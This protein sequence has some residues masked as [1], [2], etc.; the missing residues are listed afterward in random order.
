MTFLFRLVLRLECRLLC[1]VF[2]L[3]LKSVVIFWSFTSD[4]T[5]ISPSV[6]NFWSGLH[7]SRRQLS[8]VFDI[9]P[10]GNMICNLLAYRALAVNIIQKI[11][12][13]LWYDYLYTFRS[14]ILVA[15]QFVSLRKDLKFYVYVIVLTFQLSNCISWSRVSLEKIIQCS[16]R[17]YNRFMEPRSSLPFSQEPTTSPYRD[18][19]QSSPRPTNLFDI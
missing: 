13:P 3:C 16:A 5:L 6:F 12:L 17:N 11:F 9:T 4:L 14:T 10:Y 19:D 2:D 7:I 18:P 1:E 15:G 8:S